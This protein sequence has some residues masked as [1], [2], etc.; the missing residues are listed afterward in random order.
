MRSTANP[1]HGRR[2]PGEERD[3]ASERQALVA[4][5][6]GR[7]E[8]DVV[9]PLGWK[10]RVAPEHLAHGLDGHVVG[11]RLREEAVR[12]RAA[13]RRAH[14]VDVD[15]LAELG[16]GET[17]LPGAMAD[18]EERARARAGALRGRRCAAARRSGRAA[19][20]A[21]AHGQRGVGGGSLAAHA[22][23]A[24][25][26]RTSGSCARPRRYRESWPDAPPGSWGRPIGAMK[27]RL[28]A[29]DLAG[30]RDDAR[31]ALDAGAA[32]S[33]SPIGRYAAA[34]AHLVLGEDDAAGGARGDARRRATR[35][36]RR[37]PTR[38]SRSPSRDAAGVR[39]RDPGARRRLRGARGVPRGH[40]GRR[41]RARAPGAC[42]ASAASTLRST[43]PAAARG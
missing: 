16:H 35:F 20:P 24:R 13:E 33:E 31:W 43:S 32:E 10:L 41:H 4:D 21:H 6:R 17:I 27:S 38:S 9:D 14:A 18:W 12:R 19:A 8:D 2:E 40:P 34:L 3:V 1:G 11:A 37:S 36:R 39:G 5:L 42:G 28:I 26:R 23:S 15:H 7:G 29:G 25:R 30:A 22:R